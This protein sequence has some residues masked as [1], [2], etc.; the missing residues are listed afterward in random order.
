MNNQGGV[1]R[2]T[3]TFIREK[4]EENVKV[5]EKEEDKEK[6]IINIDYDLLEIVSFSLYTCTYMLR[7]ILLD[8]KNLIMETNKEHIRVEVRRKHNKNVTNKKFNKLQKK[9]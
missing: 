8:N 4:E 6:E 5:L 3:S 1:S 7:D 2:L 9:I